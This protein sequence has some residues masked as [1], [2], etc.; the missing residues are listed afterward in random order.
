MLENLFKI[1]LEMVMKKIIFT[2]PK[3]LHSGHSGIS[4]L[5]C[6]LRRGHYA[7]IWIKAKKDRHGAHVDSGFRRLL[8]EQPLHIG[9]FCVS[10]GA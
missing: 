9:S 3:Q 10:Q 1:L 4:L 6:V 5:G 7:F 8:R 2:K